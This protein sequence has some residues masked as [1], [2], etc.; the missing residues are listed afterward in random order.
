MNNPIELNILL[1][2]DLRKQIDQ[3]G[4]SEVQTFR[5]RSSFILY[6]IT[7]QGG[8]ALGILVFHY[9]VIILII[10]LFK[11]RKDSVIA[12]LLYTGATIRLAENSDPYS[13][14]LLKALPLVHGETSEEDIGESQ[15]CSKGGYGRENFGAAKN[16][17][18]LISWKVNFSFFQRRLLEIECCN[19]PYVGDVSHWASLRFLP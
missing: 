3:V 11:V 16:W 13:D 15:K 12:R 9:V 17:R 14:L 1:S 18:L 19:P 2:G 7:W 8:V 10:L 4:H 6:S 5:T